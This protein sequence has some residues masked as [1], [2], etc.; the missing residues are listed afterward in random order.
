MKSFSPRPLPPH[1]PTPFCFQ[2]T[3][4]ILPRSGKNE[5]WR[6]NPSNVADEEAIIQPRQ[7]KLFNAVHKSTRS[8]TGAPARSR[9]TCRRPLFSSLFTRHLFSQNYQLLVRAVA[10]EAMELFNHARK[11]H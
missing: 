8:E 1:T 7:W 2:L 4:T 11:F 6:T 3:F 9:L 10:S 5:T